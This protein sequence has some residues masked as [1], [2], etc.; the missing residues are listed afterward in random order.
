[1]PETVDRDSKWMSRALELAKKAWGQ[2]HPN[3]MVGAVIVE[4]GVIVAEGWHRAAGQAHAEVE[5]LRALGRKPSPQATLY[6]TLEP[7]STAGR[8]GACTDAIIESGIRQVIVGAID[9]NPDH[10]GKGLVC[11][12]NSGIE[13]SQG[14][15]AEAC[16]DLNLLFHHWIS[17]QTPL[18][19]GKIATTL[20]GKF[21]AANGHSK[22][23]T[24]EEAR[25]DVMRWRR[26]FPAIAVSAKTALADNPSLT[27]RIQ[28][29]SWCPRRFI[30]DRNFETKSQLDS[31]HIFND[32]DKERSTLVCNDKIDPTP[33]QNAGIHL[34]QLPEKEN[35]LD[36]NAFRSR[37]AEEGIHGVYIEPG[38][39]WAS[40][41]IAEQ[42]VDYFFHYIA[43]KYLV[44]TS[45]LGI[46][47]KRNTQSINE[48]FSLSRIQNESFAND[49]LVRGWLRSIKQ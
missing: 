47:K 27:S 22:W 37:C 15:M 21:S 24:G 1:M 36:L 49:L 9:P 42:S 10:G 44:D 31:L 12:R 30:L 34:W 25:A 38:P 20:D 46:H 32:S 6:V 2:T 26:Y 17:H 48:A 14:I 3:P 41:L 45:A 39:R 33:A 7:C 16:E 8:T 35:H 4:D 5:A 40:A 13:V 28:E 29:N 23:V 18:L 11:L 19:A 43:P